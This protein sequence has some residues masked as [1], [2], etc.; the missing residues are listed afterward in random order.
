V[1]RRDRPHHTSATGSA[2]RPGWHPQA[3]PPSLGPLSH[4]RPERP[5]PRAAEHQASPPSAVAGAVPWPMYA[6]E[7]GARKTPAVLTSALGGHRET[8]AFQPT[9]QRG[10]LR[11]AGFWVFRT[12]RKTHRRHRALDAAEVTGRAGPRATP[13]RHHRGV[14]PPGPPRRSG[15]PTG[16]APRTRPDRRAWPLVGSR[17]GRL[18]GA[19]T[20]PRVAAVR[21]ELD[22]V[23]DTVGVT[24]SGMMRR[25]G[26]VG[27]DAPSGG[28]WHGASPAPGMHD[29]GAD[30]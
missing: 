6:V 15:P 23:G 16:A 10:W 13:A 3:H 9:S 5:Q 29:D 19:R 4:V 22:T 26:F 17:P 21:R 24:V 20:S 25:C 7:R 28:A 18:R 1:T 27:P 11:A 14:P 12:A 2:H 8:P 30:D